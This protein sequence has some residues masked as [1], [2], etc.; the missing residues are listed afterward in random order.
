M[1][2]S[3]NSCL[4]AAACTAKLAGRDQAKMEVRELCWEQPCGQPHPLLQA[5]VVAVAADGDGEVQRQAAHL[6]TSGAHGGSAG[7]CVVKA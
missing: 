4:S 1:H 2:C 5:L 6:Q 7:R 3:S